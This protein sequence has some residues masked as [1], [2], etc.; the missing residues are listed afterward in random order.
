MTSKQLK[1]H[2]L[3]LGLTQAQVADEMF[4]TRK[5]YSGWESLGRKFPLSAQ[6]L[7]CLMYNIPFK[8]PHSKNK[9]FDNSPNLF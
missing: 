6:K 9:A 2:R 5:T 4:V 8:N 7:F 1:S 3:E